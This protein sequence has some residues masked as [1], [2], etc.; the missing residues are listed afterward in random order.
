MKIYSMIE[1][2]IGSSTK[3]QKMPTI[4]F[5]K[6]V[7]AERSWPKK[8]RNFQALYETMR[9]EL[10]M[11]KQKFWSKTLLKIYW[12]LISNIWNSWNKFVNWNK[13]MKL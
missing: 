1:Q 10:Q 13:I 9:C 7:A 6:L 11:Q 2:K 5:K 8:W 12:K 4:F 3:T